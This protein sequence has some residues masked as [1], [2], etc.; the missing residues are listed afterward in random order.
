MMKIAVVVT[1]SLRGTG[2]ATRIS[3]MLESYVANGHEVDVIH[4]RLSHEDGLQR[5]VADSVHQHVE[6]PLQDSR[7]RQ[8]IA[9]VPPIA[10]HC[11]RAGWRLWKDTVPYDVVQAETSNTW[12]V[13]RMVPARRRL[14]VIHDD[15]SIRL[16]GLARSAPDLTHRLSAELA[17]RKYSRWQRIVLGEADRA[18]FVS[19]AD[20]D[21][22]AAAL[23]KGRTRLIPNGAGDELWSVPPL[24]ESSGHEVLFTAP[25]SYEVNARGL[26]WF[27][28]EAWPFVTQH[29]PGARLRII[30]VGWEGFG[31]FPGVSFAGWCDSLV[32][33]YSRSRLAIAPLFAG[34]GTKL[35][36]VEAMAAGRPVVTT[37]VGVEDIPSSEGVSV[38]EEPREF[39]AE[40][41]RFLTCTDTARR[42]G[43]SNRIAVSDLRWSNVWARAAADLR[44]LCNESQGW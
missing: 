14:V 31:S 6:V 28:G 44:E 23:P 10:W 2:F 17:A 35:K 4:Y 5:S 13:A 1:R 42:G 9:L 26:S 25:G 32:G 36:V 34:G 24:A 3:S 30:G 16:H 29:V 37:S 8:H 11:Q 43:A 22:L 19:G 21:R 7:Y 20:Q 27:L 18:W 12:S 38:C 33:A 39:A 41:I 40:V 15:D